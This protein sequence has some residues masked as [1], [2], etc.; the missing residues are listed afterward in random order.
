M[1]QLFLALIAA[2]VFAGLGFS[3]LV[4]PAP[5]PAPVPQPVF[6][7]AV[8]R[9]NNTTGENVTLYYRWVWANGNVA[10]NWKE[11]NVPAGRQWSFWYPYQN[12]N[13]VSPN[14][15]VRYDTN[16]TNAVNF[17]EMVLK[18]GAADNFKNPRFGAIYDLRMN[19]NFAT[20]VP[21]SNFSGVT[22][23]SKNTTS[24]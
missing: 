23:T 22:V 2:L 12:G 15:F 11:V 7:Y 21:I 10:D 1:R 18:R 16:R 14:F 4:Q 17:W 13:T 5:A 3:Q 24:P 20:M 19:G 8:V 9:I 6:K